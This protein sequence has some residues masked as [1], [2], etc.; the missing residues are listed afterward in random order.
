MEN[1]GLEKYDAL[2]APIES[3]PPPKTDGVRGGQ[4]QAPTFIYHRDKFYD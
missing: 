3:A 1:K 2:Q 4:I